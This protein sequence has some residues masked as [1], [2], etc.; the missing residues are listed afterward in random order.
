M[1]DYFTETEILPIT[2]NLLHVMDGGYLLPKVV[3]QKND[4]I[5]EITEK[6]L[7]YVRHNY[8]ENS[9]IVFDGYADEDGGVFS[10]KAME[11]SRRKG[12]SI[13]PSFHL[14]PHTQI[15]ITQ[16]K[17]LSNDKNKIELIKYLAKAFEF[18][19]YAI[20]QEEEDADTLINNTAIT[21]AQSIKCEQ[22]ANLLS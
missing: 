20:Q 18:E 7:N 4:T 5:E 21:I 3:W 16:S 12:T 19:G 2:N 6:F 10:T 1:F 9:T 13:I 8:A 22:L 11:R 14:E 15:T 17:F